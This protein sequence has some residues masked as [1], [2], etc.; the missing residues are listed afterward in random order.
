MDIG[1]NFVDKTCSGLGSN[2]HIVD[3]NMLG[4]NRVKSVSNGI[5]G[6]DKFVSNLDRGNDV[7]NAANMIDVCDRGRVKIGENRAVIREVYSSIE[8]IEDVKFLK[9]L[10]FNARSIKTKLEEFKLM[11]EEK[12][13]SIIAI[14]ESWLT[15]DILDCEI[16]LKN[17]DMIR[18][19]R[20]SEKK[21]RGGGVLIYVNQCMNYTKIEAETINNLE[22]IWIRVHSRGCDAVH[23]GV[24]YRPPDGDEEQIKNLIKK[25]S[26]FQTSRT[27][28]IGDFNF[29]NINWKK[30][31]SDRKGREFIKSV[32][33]LAL[34]Q[35]VKKKTR[36]DNILDLVLVYESNLV[37]RLKHF[38]PIGKSDHDTLCITLNT[39]ITKL[40]QGL[41]MFNYNKANYKLLQ[42]EFSKIDWDEES[43]RRSVND[44]WILLSGVLNNFKEK[45]IQK[46]KNRMNNEVPWMSERIKKMIKKRNNLYKRFSK[47]KNIYFKIKYK[48]LRNKV[49]KQIRMA[50]GKYESKIIRRSKN[51]R[52]IFY[53]YVNGSKKGG[54]SRKIGPLSR[55]REED[56]EEDLVEDDKEVAEI[57]NEYFCSVFNSDIKGDNKNS[58]MEVSDQGDVIENIDI[59][60]EDVKKGYILF[61]ES[62]NKSALYNEYA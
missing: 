51:N 54:S 50:K 37:F 58:M 14:V 40:E 8:D 25:I 30:N 27:I 7:G 17:F 34:H 29:R 26:K 33:K 45:H 12:K 18:M 23:I 21:E 16:K 42:N 46:F 60:D 39:N 15:E 31:S 28:L 4:S 3:D 55:K 6:V 11:V 52:K 5:D 2:Y 43:K 44:F 38:A 32:K 1:S 61:N 20:S 36:G 13:P 35:M 41:N 10:Y 48:Q 24:F 57:L 22:Y 49:T 47:S 56:G 19:D 59:T 9:I 62:F 53:T